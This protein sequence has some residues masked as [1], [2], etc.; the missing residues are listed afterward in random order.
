M[1]ERRKNSITSDFRS[2]TPAGSDAI[3]AYVTVK[4]FPA[5]SNEGSIGRPFISV[6]VSLIGYIDSDGCLTLFY[7]SMAP[8]G[9]AAQSEAQGTQID[10]L[11]LSD[12]VR[13]QKKNI[14]EDLFSSVLTQLEKYRPSRNLKFNH[15]GIFQN[16]KLLL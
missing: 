2:A 6:T 15:L 3:L 14:L 10:P 16:F 13:E 4:P 7:V 9:A 8:S 12:T 5:K 11:P 1:R